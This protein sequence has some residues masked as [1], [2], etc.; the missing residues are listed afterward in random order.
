[1]TDDQYRMYG[2]LPP[3][4]FLAELE[5]LEAPQETPEPRYATLE[6]ELVRR[7]HWILGLAGGCV[8]LFLWVLYL[9]TA[10]APIGAPTPCAR[11]VM[12]LG[13]EVHEL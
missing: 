2:Q 7:E 11:E 8:V 4:E 9:A 3:D 13:T 12:E 5:G 10:Y 6:R 1:M